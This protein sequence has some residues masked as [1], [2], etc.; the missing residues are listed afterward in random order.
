LLDQVGNFA[1]R[2]HFWRRSSSYYPALISRL[3]LILADC[4]ALR[5]NESR[6]NVIEEIQKFPS[7]VHAGELASDLYRYWV[8]P[9][10]QSVG[11]FFLDVQQDLIDF[12]II[13]RE[14]VPSVNAILL[15][16]VLT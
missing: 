14:R 6:K 12:A 11:V 4:G 7:E 3:E 13:I 2:I 9:I 1:M 10:T 8:L 16:S 5:C 15:P